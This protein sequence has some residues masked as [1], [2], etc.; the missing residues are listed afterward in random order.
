MVGSSDQSFDQGRH[1][2]STLEF[3]VVLAL[4]LVGYFAL[5]LFVINDVVALPVISGDG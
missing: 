2:M 3:V 4:A 1:Q 5:K